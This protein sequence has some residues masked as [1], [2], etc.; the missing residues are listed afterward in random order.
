MNL[1]RGEKEKEE[2]EENQMVEPVQEEGAQSEEAPQEETPQSEEAP[3]EEEP[4]G[5]EAAQEEE[6]ES[7]EAAQEEEAPQEEG[8]SAEEYRK[9]LLSGGIAERA[10]SLRGKSSA[11]PEEGIRIL[12]EILGATPANPVPTEVFDLIMRGLSYATDVAQA[13]SEG[14]VAG[15]NTRID[16]LTAQGAERG[17]G[18]SRI[19]G[20]PDEW[21]DT[22]CEGYTPG[23]IFDL[24]FLAR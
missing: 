10:E 7:E 23:S 21:S 15:R 5:E 20:K 13:Y 3:Q 1:G 18:V 4:Q 12:E 14:E 16:Q 24:A 19:K 2:Q 22:P 17:D 9:K 11:D 8:T 6:P